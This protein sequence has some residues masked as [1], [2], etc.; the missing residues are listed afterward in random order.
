MLA[1]TEYDKVSAQVCKENIQCISSTDTH[2]KQAAKYFYIWS[3]QYMNFI[4]R[5]VW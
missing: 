4:H 3:M 1:Y 2:G 5:L